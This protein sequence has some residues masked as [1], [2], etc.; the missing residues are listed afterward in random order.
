M[1]LKDKIANL[2]KKEFDL[3]EVYTTE[4]T[5]NPKRNMPMP[6]R[7]YLHRKSIREGFE[8]YEEAKSSGN[9]VEF[10]EGDLYFVNKFKKTPLTAKQVA[11][12]NKELNKE[13]EKETD[14]GM[15][16]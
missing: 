10:E 6:V 15:E 1:R 12:V 14:N 2:T 7:I 11:Y 3:G 16:K 5:E 8:D 9:A 13:I 4:V